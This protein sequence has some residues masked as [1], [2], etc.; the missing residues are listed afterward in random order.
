MSEAALDGMASPP[1]GYSDKPAYMLCVPHAAAEAVAMSEA[2]LDGM[3]SP[4]MGYSDDET[5]DSG[6]GLPPTT[7]GLHR[8][9]GSGGGS[10]G[11]VEAAAEVLRGR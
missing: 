7:L 4:P 1:M 10:G 2:A 9:G 5:E 6:L 8:N 11:A 3:A